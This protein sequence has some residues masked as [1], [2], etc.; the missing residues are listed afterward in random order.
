MIIFWLTK[1]LK[2]VSTSDAEILIVDIKNKKLHSHTIIKDLEPSFSNITLAY[3]ELKGYEIPIVDETG[4]VRCEKGKHYYSIYQ[5]TDNYPFY[6]VEHIEYNKNIDDE[7]Y[8]HNNYFRT[9]EQAG[10]VIDKIEL[11]LRLKHLQMKYCPDYKPKWDRSETKCSI[12][13][14]Y[15]DRKFYFSYVPFY[16]DETKTDIYFPSDGEIAQKVCDELNGI[17]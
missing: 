1:L 11:L 8:I 10:E 16:V 12:K 15:K 6:P 13:Y 9:S 5:S 4:S 17:I 2:I 3:A 7:R 14:D